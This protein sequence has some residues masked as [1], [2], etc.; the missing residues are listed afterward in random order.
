MFDLVLVSRSVM[1]RCHGNQFRRPKSAK[2]SE[3]P[4]FFGHES[5]NGWQNGKADGRMN[6][7]DVLTTS[8]KNLMN[9]G[10]LTPEF[11]VIIWQPFRR[12][13]GEIGET[14]TLRVAFVD[15]FPPKAAQR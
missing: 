2:I 7:P 13:M 4:S 9:F 12:Q 6:T 3:T 8:H 10:Q 14:H 1:G 5:H 11:T 15:R